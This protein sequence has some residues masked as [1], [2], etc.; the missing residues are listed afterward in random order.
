[1]IK[2][3]I[4]NLGSLF[5]D[6]AFKCQE[7]IA[8]KEVNGNSIIFKDLDYL[9]NQIAHFI[10]SKGIKKGDVIAI[11]NDKSKE[12]YAIMLACLKI[13]VIYT[14]LD[15]KSPK[16]RFDKM[17]K[18][19]K[20]NLIFYYNN[21]NLLSQEVTKYNEIESICYDAESFKKRIESSSILFPKVNKDV[22]GSTPAYI[23]FTSGS[24]G[25]PKGV[26][27]KHES[28]LNFISWVKQTYSITIK[29]VFTNIN[30]LHFDNSVFDFYGS[31][32]NGAALIPVKE[33]LTINPRK[34]LEELNKVEPTIWFSVPSMLVYVLNMRALREND[35][36]SLRIVTFGGEGFPK[37][38]LRSL[39]KFWGKRVEFVNVYGP[40]EGTCICSS[41]KVTKEDLLNDDLL[42]LGPIAPNFYQLIL[43]DKND[44]VIKDEIGELC[45]G[46]PNLA[47]GYY[48]NKD[49]TDANFVNNPFLTEFDEKIYKT[50]DLVKFNK[51]ENLLYFCGRKDNQIK[52]MG[53]R[54]ELEEIENAFNSIPF[55]EESAVIYL[56]TNTYKSKIIACLR[57]G[58]KNEKDIKLELKK[59][60]PLYMIPD[61]YYFYDILPKNQNGKINR[62]ALKEE[63]S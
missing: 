26:V 20:P 22:T 35:L 30:P 17:I 34:L 47:L 29:D 13:G 59:K 27:I 44:K 23:M 14:N 54:I 37:N 63:L 2:D 1:M 19:C 39:W 52:R 43:T 31:L 42:P 33:N 12:G 40:T 48:N 3:Y 60:L 10:L 62:L 36:P 16:E 15:S 21:Q 61:L 25:F 55:I 32:F 41:Y 28:L 49:K 6:I 38:S 8:L 4:Y 51:E 58:N 11:L 46:G 5:T 53:Y 57:T 18:V 9:S 7:K 45:I 24:T 50:G 56:D